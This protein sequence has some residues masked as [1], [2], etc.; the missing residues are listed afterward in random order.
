MMVEGFEIIEKYP[1]KKTNNLFYSSYSSNLL[2]NTSV[3][4]I[5]IRNVEQSK[6]DV[7]SDVSYRFTSFKPRS[8]NTALFAEMA[9][10][11]IA[12]HRKCLSTLLL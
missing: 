8:R 12:E 4:T 5:F 1:V 10:N 6:R 3:E 2:C 9:F 7:S 11:M